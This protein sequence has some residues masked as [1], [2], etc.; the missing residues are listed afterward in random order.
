MF[1]LRLK[2]TCI[3]NTA[4]YSV[5]P[6]CSNDLLLHVPYEVNFDDVTCHKA[7][8][9]AYGDGVAVIVNDADRG[10]VLKLDGK[11]RLEVTEIAFQRPFNFSHV[12]WH[13]YYV[14]IHFVTTKLFQPTAHL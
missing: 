3:S 6:T 9:Y 11:V 13:S 7:K 12:M 1:L 2:N 8:G 4:L 14:L 10:N 5:N